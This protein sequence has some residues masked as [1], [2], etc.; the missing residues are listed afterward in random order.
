MHCKRP[1]VNSELYRLTD[2]PTY[3]YETIPETTGETPRQFEVKQSMKDAALTHDPATG[4]HV[5]RVLQS[6]YLNTQRWTRSSGTSAPY[7]PTAG[8]HCCGVNGCGPH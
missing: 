4:R 8:G 5:R 2:M 7:Q 1:P 6:G 3:V